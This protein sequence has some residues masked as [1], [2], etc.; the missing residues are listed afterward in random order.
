[1]R[2][3]QERAE[4][5]RSLRIAVVRLC[6]STNAYFLSLNVVTLSEWAC[7]SLDVFCRSWRPS[8]PSP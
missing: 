7:R 5:A 6:I 4:G 8:L 3:E 2:V 1:M